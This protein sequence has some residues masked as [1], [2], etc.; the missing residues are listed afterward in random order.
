MIYNFHLTY[1]QP[2]A[3]HE[4]LKNIFYLRF[5][6]TP[7]SDLVVVV[8][9]GGGL[10]PFFVAF[11]LQSP[12]SPKNSI[13]ELTTVYKMIMGPFNDASRQITELDKWPKW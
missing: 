1:P 3:K 4:V 7:R 9:V 6:R 8:V 11:I 2:V 10:L 5:V 13:T 12:P